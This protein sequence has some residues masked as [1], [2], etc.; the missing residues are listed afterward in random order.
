MTDLAIPL[1]VAYYFLIP[2]KQAE[3]GDKVLSWPIFFYESGH[4]K[5]HGEEENI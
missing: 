2:G 1:T 4:I 5:T 3:D